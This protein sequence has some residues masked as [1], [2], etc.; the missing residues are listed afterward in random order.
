MEDWLWVE[1]PFLAPMEAG[2][3]LE[4]M[5]LTTEN[6]AWFYDLSLVDEGSMC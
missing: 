4:N 6:T 3:L 2:N 5:Q 1:G